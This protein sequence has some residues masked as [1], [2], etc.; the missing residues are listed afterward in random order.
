VPLLAVGAG[1]Y[2]VK[3]AKSKPRKLNLSEIELRKLL[4]DIGSWHIFFK[5][6]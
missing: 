6:D 3:K 5:L 4:L 2:V 1:V